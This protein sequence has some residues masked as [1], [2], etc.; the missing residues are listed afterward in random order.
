[1]T[2]GP[3]YVENF[4][5]IIIVIHDLTIV[6]QNQD[7]IFNSQRTHHNSKWNKCGHT[8]KNTCT[9]NC[10]KDLPSWKMYPCTNAE[11]IARVQPLLVLMF[12]INPREGTFFAT[13]FLEMNCTEVMEQ[14]FTENS[15][16]Y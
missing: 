13:M 8:G 1:M 9:S 11:D 10:Q 6:M 5:A 3:Q 15:R 4:S 12:F 2:Y 7:R 14:L 16:V